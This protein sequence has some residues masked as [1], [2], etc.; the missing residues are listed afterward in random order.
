[1]TGS[2]TDELRV[3]GQHVYDAVTQDLATLERLF[4]PEGAS[5]MRTFDS[6]GMIL[7]QDIVCAREDGMD[8]LLRRSTSSKSPP[9]RTE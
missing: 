8:R 4:T 1:M 6:Y 5:L 7:R 3:L 9:V 2:D